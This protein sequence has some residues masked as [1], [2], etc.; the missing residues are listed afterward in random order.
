[1]KKA[2][3][4]ITIAA[5][6]ATLAGSIVFARTLEE[7]RDAVRAYLKVVDAKIIKYR[8]AGDKVKMVKLQKEKQGTLARWNKLKAQMAAPATVAPAPPPPPVAPVPP[9]APVAV[10]AAPTGALF[11]W[12]LETAWTGTYL[13]TG[14]GKI[15]GGLGA[16]AEV[17]LDD[18]FGLGSMVG[19]TAN[20][21]K[22]K[23][24]LG[25]HYGVDI[26]GTRIKAIPI[27]LDAM[28]MLPAEWIGGMATY[29]GGGL[30]YTIYG[31][32][33]KAGSYGAEVYVGMLT[34]LGLG[35]GKTGIELG[36]AA[37]RAN[38]SSPALSAK[39]LTLSVS[40]MVTL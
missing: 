31:S 33:Q 23:V 11:G 19:L 9:P 14:K 1:M 6:V 12:G 7:E 8:T 35:L 28:V 15:N 13:M 30:N 38:G 10:K 32:G 40:Q 3:V 39:G 4:V 20:S 26:N 36:W 5:F 27:N 2:L 25:G 21:V 22:W 34:D 29:V 18:M 16:K 17:V 24:G 37:I